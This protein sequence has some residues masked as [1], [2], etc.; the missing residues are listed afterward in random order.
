MWPNASCSVTPEPH[1]DGIDNDH[2]TMRL[3]GSSMVS[4]STATNSG[5]DFVNDRGT[6]KLADTTS[7]IRS[8]ARRRGGRM[9]NQ[10][11]TVRQMGWSREIRNMP[12]NSVR[13]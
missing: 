6:V 10:R 7:A 13:G 12:D 5:G 2:G 1:G 9:F 3:N 8:T 11:G 4:R